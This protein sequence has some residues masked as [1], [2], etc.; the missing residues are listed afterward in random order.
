MICKFGYEPDCFAPMPEACLEGWVYTPP[1]PA[2]NDVAEQYNNANEENDD[3][4]DTLVD[5]DDD[6]LEDLL[7][8]DNPDPDEIRETVG[9]IKHRLQQQLEEASC[10]NAEL[11]AK[12]R[13]AH[14]KNVQDIF[15]V[16]AEPLNCT[17]HQFLQLLE[18][19]LCFNA[20]YRSSYSFVNKSHADKDEFQENI[21]KMMLMI[22]TYL[23]RREGNGW[24][25]QN[26]MSCC[27]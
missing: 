8:Q 27:M 10:Q 9:I 14:R 26:S 6:D 17:L 13:A 1:A 12:L 21:R 22:T 18:K 3:D 20:L 15:A 25:L 19:I 11:R 4:D 16:K 23:P 24:K 5:D 7:D 2:N